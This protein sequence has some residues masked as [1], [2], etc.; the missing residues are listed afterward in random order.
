MPV[1][2]RRVRAVRAL[3]TASYFNWMLLDCISELSGY[4]HVRRTREIKLSWAV[5]I[6][7]RVEARVYV[8]RI[9]QT[10]SIG[11]CHLHWSIICRLFFL[12]LGPTK[13][14]IIL[15]KNYQLW[16]FYCHNFWFCFLSVIHLDEIWLSYVWVVNHHLN[17]RPRSWSA[18]CLQLN[19]LF[20]F[21]HALISIVCGLN[22]AGPKNLSRRIKCL[23]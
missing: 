3:V 20:V 21:Q 19:L 17:F 12:Y 4:I 6:R 5:D 7:A 2:E 1:D 10:S 13:F 8:N 16:F 14:Y 18:A 23:L 22:R 11:C 15:F 9:A